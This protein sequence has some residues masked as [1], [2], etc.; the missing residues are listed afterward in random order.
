MSRTYCALLLLAVL[1]G[2]KS[3]VSKYCTASQACDEGLPICDVEGVCSESDYITNTCISVACWDAAVGATDA[4]VADALVAVDGAADANVAPDAGPPPLTNPWSAPVLVPEL[5]DPDVYDYKP[6]L[7]G[8]RLEA[9]F[10]RPFPQAYIQWSTR[11]STTGKWSSPIR[12]IGNFGNP[13]LSADGLEIYV[14]V[15][16]TIRRATRATTD[17]GFGSF[18]DQFAG[19]SP[20]ITG[21]GLTIYYVDTSGFLRRRH[22]SA[23]GAGWGS[24]EAVLL[25][26]L[27]SYQSIAVSRD[28]LVI[29]LAA[30]VKQGDPFNVE[31]VRPDRASSWQGPFE[32]T[33]VTLLGG[34]GCNLPSGWEMF[35]AL[36]NPSTGNTDIY[37]LVRE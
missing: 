30:N 37:R 20:S 3:K 29:S 13:E 7:R 4:G 17:T 8:D 22:R 34:G 33:P 24:E 31:F 26:G 35:C 6:T 5:S 9:Y 11:A 2:C 25:P 36:M 16:S 18:S 12:S 19:V 23:V 10:Y 21:D 15:S 27:P 14:V 1:A 32:I 28:E